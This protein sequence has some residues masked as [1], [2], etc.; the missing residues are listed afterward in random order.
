MVRWFTFHL[1]VD[2]LQ[3]TLD[4]KQILLKFCCT[5]QHPD[6]IFLIF[7]YQR[8]CYPVDPT[9][10][11]EYGVSGEPADDATAAAAAAAASPPAVDGV[12]AADYVTADKKEMQEEEDG[13]TAAAEANAS[14]AA[15]AVAEEAKLTKRK[16]KGKGAVK[17]EQ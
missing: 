15:N 5:H 16:G 7:L 17:A 4:S 11:N 1:S 6:L 14:N 13:A 2:I 12:A 9:R 3:Q 8:W 10:Y